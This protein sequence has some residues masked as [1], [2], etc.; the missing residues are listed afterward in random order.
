MSWGRGNLPKQ[1][2]FVDRVYEITISKYFAD[3]IIKWFEVLSKLKINNWP[4]TEALH[5]FCIIIRY[6]N[7]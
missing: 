1:A 7:V 2:N 5:Y 4:Y 6:K 3:A